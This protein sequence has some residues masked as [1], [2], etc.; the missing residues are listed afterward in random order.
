MVRFGRVGFCVDEFEQLD[1]YLGVDGGGFEFFV[2]EELLDEADVGSAYKHVGGAGVPQEVAG[3][4][5]SDVG[6]FDVF[7]H[8]AA[9]DVGTILLNQPV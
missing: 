1:A 9:E 4:G 3:A 6:G 2:T 7:A 5:A 8:H